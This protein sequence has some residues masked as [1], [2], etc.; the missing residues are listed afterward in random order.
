[1]QFD[2]RYL[3]FI[4]II[5]YI[6]INIIIYNIILYIYNITIFIYIYIYMYHAYSCACYNFANKL[7]N[8]IM[9]MHIVVS[10]LAEQMD[11]FAIQKY[12]G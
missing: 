4:A 5:L 7:I 10:R 6:I 2:L 3:I 9:I 12:G 11:M 1:M 8:V